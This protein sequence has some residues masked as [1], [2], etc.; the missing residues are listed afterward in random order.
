MQGLVP[1]NKVGLTSVQT[2]CN[3]VKA[4]KFCGLIYEV[5]L[6]VWPINWLASSH[7][8][9]TAAAWLILFVPCNLGTMER[10]CISDIMQPF[11]GQIILSHCIQDSLLH[12][13][14]P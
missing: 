1:V 7:Y 9:L 14:D 6:K 11:L 5:V 12:K 3:S 4:N 10:E 8:R 2:I 13:N